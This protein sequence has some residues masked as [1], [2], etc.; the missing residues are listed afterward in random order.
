V[1][2]KDSINTTALPTTGGTPALANNRPKSNAPAA[3]ALFD[4]G[5][6]L[7]AKANLHEVSFGATSNNAFT[8]AVHNPYNLALIPGGSS[9]GNGAAAAARMCPAGLGADAAGS[10]R[11]PA[12]LCG[13]AGLRPSIGRYPGSGATSGPDAQIFNV[14]PAS[15]TRDT[16]GPMARTVADLVLLDSVVTGDFSAIKPVN[17]KG[18]RL[19]IASYFFTD[20]DPDVETVIGNVLAELTN[21]GVILVLAD[22]PNIGT[23]DG[24]GFPITFHE[25]PI[26][27]AQYLSA[28][29]PTV[30]LTALIDQVASPDVKAALE[31]ILPGG[32]NFVDIA[33]YNTALAMRAQLQA[34]YANYF[35][36]NNIAALIFP[37][38]ILPARPIGQDSTVELNGQQVN[39]FLAYVHN[40]DPGSIAGIPGLS[41]PAGLT[42]D[43]LPVGLGLDGPAGSDRALLAIGLAIE[44]VLGPLP[45]PNLPGSQAGRAR[46]RA[47]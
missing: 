44:Q 29:D 13:I 21:L 2:L 14:V 43:G 25:A 22:V 42:S 24:A 10:V 15:S 34:T 47:Y 41:L 31:S 12:A 16:T 28:N 20:L 3:Q 6:I 27:L 7:F 35:V 19:G 5:A 39:T 23:F 38:T 26:V 37:T 46:F 4:A 18:I 1:I 45:P 36:S 33:A 17:L 11:I 9:G 30:T 32:P 40:T 8:G